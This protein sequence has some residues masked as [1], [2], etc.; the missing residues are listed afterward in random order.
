[1]TDFKM[2][3]VTNLSTVSA[4]FLAMSP[5]RKM[6]LENA[7]ELF[8]SV[9][10]QTDLLKMTIKSAIARKHPPSVKYQEAFLKTLIQQ[11]E[12][13][14]YE[15]GDDLY[16]VY[17]ALLSSS[18]S[19][20]N[21]ECY[22]TYLLS[23]TNDTSVT[24]KESVKMI[25]EGTTGLNTWPAAGLLA[26]WAMENKDALSGRTILEL[27]SGMGL[28]GL[29][30]CKTCQPNGY[31]FSDCHDS[32]LKGLKENIAINVPGDPE[33]GSVAPEIDTEDTKGDRIPDI[34][35]ECID[36]KAFE[37]NDLQRL[38]AGVILA[39]DVV[40]DPRIIEHL[41]RLLRLLLRCQGDGQGRP[42]A[43]IASTI[44]NEDTYWAFLQALDKYHVST[45]K[46]EIPAHKTL[47]FDRSCRIHILR[48]WLPV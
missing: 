27:G 5:V 20:T 23:N 24:L 33:Q 31:I 30:I 14:Y 9:E 40:F 34:S 32:V 2:E 42:T 18:K 8:Q 41:V 28:T 13:K 4:Q 7:D 38:N 45:E 44:R 36:W 48:L 22:R 37:K 1:M 17:T 29:T 10:S 47:H 12:A 15:I 26:E 11:C 3:D 46:M 6:G 19:E 43:F 16:E 21:D 25:S 35:V 39:A